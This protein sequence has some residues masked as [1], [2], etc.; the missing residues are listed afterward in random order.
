MKNIW[1]KRPEVLFI[2]TNF[3]NKHV[4][5][6]HYYH[7]CQLLVVQAHQND[8]HTGTPYFFLLQSPCAEEDIR[9]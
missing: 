9:M 8:G 3:K 6:I 1:V 2:G 4:I 5:V 7:A